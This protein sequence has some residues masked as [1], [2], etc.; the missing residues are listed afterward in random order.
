MTKSKIIG[1]AGVVALG[2]P[3]AGVAHDNGRGTDNNVKQGHQ[4]HHG[5]H[6]HHGHGKA[7]RDLLF[8]G[9]LTSVDAAAGTAVVQVTKTNRGAR[10][11]DEKAVSFTLAGA[12]LNVADRNANGALDAGDLVAGDKVIVKVRL[13]K[14]ATAAEPFAAAKLHDVTAPRARDASF[15]ADRHECSKDKAAR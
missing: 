11:W 9:T 12:K 5:H 3:A 14:G 6:G 1:L 7:K 10:A 13:A 4:G 8:G 2:L 15:R